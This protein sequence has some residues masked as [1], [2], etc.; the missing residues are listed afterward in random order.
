MYCKLCAFVMFRV[1]HFEFHTC[2]IEGF[3]ALE[4]HYCYY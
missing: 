4:M 2:I 3:S 1:A